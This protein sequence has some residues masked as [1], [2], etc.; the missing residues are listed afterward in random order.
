MRKRRF[1][2]VLFVFFV[3][4]VMVSSYAMAAANTV[5][6]T[7]LE[8]ITMTINIS[9]VPVECVGMTFVK[10]KDDLIFQPPYD[11]GNGNDCLVGTTGN[12]TMNG[13]PG[14]DVLVG[15]GGQ[16]TLNGGQG[17]NDVCWGTCQSTFIGCEVINYYTS[18]S[19]PTST[20]RF[21]FLSLTTPTSTSLISTETTNTVP[22]SMEL[23][24]TEIIDTTPTITDL[25]G[26]I[27][28]STE[29]TSMIPTIVEPTK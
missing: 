2:I 9:N 4:I 12:D 27:T 1:F 16:D 6:V 25:T 24:S 10:G 21:L 26:T 17:N 15:N 13:G 11:G 18:C 8:D 20:P 5:P 7:A 23:T 29:P 19:T 28:T 14:N 22:T 3:M